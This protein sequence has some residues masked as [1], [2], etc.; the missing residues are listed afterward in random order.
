MWRQLVHEEKV[1]TL[2]IAAMSIQVI[3]ANDMRALK[4]NAVRKKSEWDNPREGFVHIS[5]W[6]QALMHKTFQVELVR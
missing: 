1:P 5:M 2:S 4:K 3:T 6:M